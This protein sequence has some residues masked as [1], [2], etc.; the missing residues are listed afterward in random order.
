[1]LK[2]S[3]LEEDENMKSF[4]ENLHKEDNSI[5]DLAKIIAGDFPLEVDLK[6]IKFEDL[7]EIVYENAGDRR[8]VSKSADGERWITLSQSNLIQLRSINNL[9]HQENGSDI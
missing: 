1:M 9:T 5:L 7:I 6:R 2:K 3:L 4:Y 8:L